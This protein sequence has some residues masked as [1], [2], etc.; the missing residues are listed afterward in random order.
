MKPEL[1]KCGFHQMGEILK[2]RYIEEQCQELHD[3]LEVHI[4][5]TE[6]RAPSR[7]DDFKLERP[8]AR[9]WRRGEAELER[10]IWEEFN[11]KVPTSRKFFPDVCNRVVSYQVPLRSRKKDDDKGKFN[12]NWGKIDLVGIDDN[13]HPTVIEIKK[14]DSTEPP[15]RML[16]EAVAY[17]IVLRRLWNLPESHFQAEWAKAI[18]K[19]KVPDLRKITLILMAPEQY[20]NRCMGKAGNRG[21]VNNEGWISFKKLVNK[22]EEKGSFR[23]VFANLKYDP[24]TQRKFEN[25]SAKKIVPWGL[26]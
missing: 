26:I 6:D 13:S 1:S 5:L 10:G 16:T 23:I 18:K 14:D 12:K 25:F 3:N 21:K 20:W 22:L 15:S 4:K 9:Q 17:G 7:R 11:L 19:E 24:G 8:D 2:L